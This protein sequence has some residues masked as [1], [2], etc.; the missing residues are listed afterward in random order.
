MYQKT[1]LMKPYPNQADQGRF[2]ETGNEADRMMFKVPSLRNISKTAPYFHDGLAETLEDAVAI[3]A[4]YQLNR[5]LD[6]QTVASIVTFLKTLDNQK[7]FKR[8]TK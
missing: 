5:K 8:T 6:E 4:E 1:G 3:M 7:E 2:D